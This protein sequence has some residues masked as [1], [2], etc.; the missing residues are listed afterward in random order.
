MAEGPGG[1]RLGPR[2]ATSAI[3]L[4]L[5]GLPLVLVRY[6]R[7]PT[8]EDF[9]AME[10]WCR[11]ELYPRRVRFVAVSDLSAIGMV[12]RSV[13]KEGAAMAHRVE[14]FVIELEIASVLLVTNPLVRGILKAIRWLTPAIAPEHLVSD[15]PS[16]AELAERLLR[17]EGVELTP[18]TLDALERIRRT[19]GT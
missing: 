15:G 13:R 14:P 16:A 1:E 19:F 7:V 5:E 8:V 10:R 3:E 2:H 6:R 9:A 18:P 4:D 12:D 17:R 11:T